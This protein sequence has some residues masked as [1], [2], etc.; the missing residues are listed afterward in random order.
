M[1][2]PT[3]CIFGFPA[4]T[5]RSKNPRRVGL[6]RIPVNVGRYSDFRSRAFP[7]FD[8]RV[9]PRTLD[10]LLNSRRDSPQYAAAAAWAT[11]RP[12]GSQAPGL[13]FWGFTSSRF[14]GFA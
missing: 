6:N 12:W 9:R 3:A 7:A 2:A 14:P 13:G 11:M 10:P 1:H 4:A 8:S 5:S